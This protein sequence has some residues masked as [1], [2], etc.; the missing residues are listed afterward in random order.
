MRNPVIA[1]L[2]LRRIE[3]YLGGKSSTSLPAGTSGIAQSNIATGSSSSVLLP[4]HVT[5]TNNGHP[6]NPSNFASVRSLSIANSLSPI[7]SSVLPSQILVLTGSTVSARELRNLVATLFPIDTHELRIVS[8]TGFLRLIHEIYASSLHLPTSNVWDNALLHSGAPSSDSRSSSSSSSSSFLSSSSWS[9]TG[10]NRST[11]LSSRFESRAALRSIIHR[12][13]LEFYRPPN[14]PFKYLDIIHRYFEQLA[15]AGISPEEF[16]SGRPKFSSGDPIFSSS[17]SSSNHSSVSSVFPNLER[18]EISR[19]KELARAYNEWIM[20]KSRVG[21]LSS[22]DAILS[23]L[24]I[25]RKRDYVP[26]ILQATTSTEADPS[27]STFPDN[28]SYEVSHSAVLSYLQNEIRHVLC[29]DIEDYDLGVLRILHAAFGTASVQSAV[30]TTAEIVDSLS[31]KETKKKSTTKTRK[32]KETIKIEIDTL[33]PTTIVPPISATIRT[34]ELFM[35]TA[36]MNSQDCYTL[37]AKKQLLQSMGISSNKYYSSTTGLKLNGNERSGIDPI[38]PFQWYMYPVDS[39]SSQC[40]THISTACHR[41]NSANKI[42]EG[43]DNAT[44]PS[45]DTT[46]YLATSPTN[47]NSSIASSTTTGGSAKP[48]KRKKSTAS[49]TTPDATKQ[50]QS[51][52]ASSQYSEMSAQYAQALSIVPTVPGSSVPGFVECIGLQSTGNEVRAIAQSIK[53]LLTKEGLKDQNHSNKEYRSIAVLCKSNTVATEIGAALQNELSSLSLTLPLGFASPPSSD[54]DNETSINAVVSTKAGSKNST[55]NIYSDGHAELSRVPEVRWILAFLGVL[56]QPRDQSNWYTLASSPLYNIPLPTVADWVR[57]ALADPEQAGSVLRVIQEASAP[58]LRSLKGS[59]LSTKK[60]LPPRP[61]MELN[62]LASTTTTWGNG[63][64]DTEDEGQTVSSA[65]P[66]SSGSTEKLPRVPDEGKGSDSEGAFGIVLPPIR[67]PSDAILT[68]SS[69]QSL[70]LSSHVPNTLFPTVE[71]AARQLLDDLRG[72]T[73]EQN[74][75]GSVAKALAWY[76]RKTD[77]LT[78]LRE[79]T[80]PAQADAAAALAALLTLIHR[81]ERRQGSEGLKSA[82]RRLSRQNL[83]EDDFVVQQSSRQSESEVFNAILSTPTVKVELALDGLAPVFEAVK[84]AVYAGRLRYVSNSTVNNSSA[85]AVKQPTGAL[86]AAGGEGD[87]DEEIIDVVDTINLF[88]NQTVAGNMQNRATAASLSDSENERMIAVHSAATEIGLATSTVDDANGTVKEEMMEDLVMNVGDAASQKTFEQITQTVENDSTL[89]KLDK[90]LNNAE[91]YRIVSRTDPSSIVI[92]LQSLKGS[93]TRPFVVVTT[94]HRGIEHN[95]DVIIFPNCTNTS[96]P[97]RYLSDNL[98]LPVSLFTGTIG[99]PTVPYT[100]VS[101]DATPTSTS[102][103]SPIATKSTRP[104][105]N[106]SSASD[107]IEYDV[108]SPAILP[109]PN[110]RLEFEALSRAQLLRAMARAREGI[111]FFC[112]GVPT[113]ESGVSTRTSRSKWL[114]YIFGSPPLKRTRKSK[115]TTVN[116]EETEELP[117]QTNVILPSNTLVSSTNKTMMSVLPSL[118]FSSLSDYDWCPWKFKLRKIDKLVPLPAANVEYG[119]ALHASVAAVA[120]LVYRPLYSYLE[121]QGIFNDYGLDTRNNASELSSTD[122]AQISLQRAIIALDFGQRNSNATNDLKKQIISK[123][124]TMDYCTSVMLSAYKDSWVPTSTE[125]GSSVNTNDKGRSNTAWCA[126]YPSQSNLSKGIINGSLAKDQTYIRNAVDTLLLDA[127]EIRAYEPFALEAIHNFA[128]RELTEIRSLL[129]DNG[130]SYGNRLGSGNVSVL[131]LVEQHFQLSIPI[132]IPIPNPSSPTS[133]NN[134]DEKMLGNGVTDNH[135]T[136]NSNLVHLS[137]YIDRIDV[138]CLPPENSGQYRDGSNSYETNIREYKSGQQWKRNTSMALRDKLRTLQ[139]DIYGMAVKNM[140]TNTS[141]SSANRSRIPPLNPIVQVSVESIE[142]GNAESR[143]I[144]TT[145]IQK[146]HE[147]ILTLAERIRLQEFKP[148]PSEIA[149]KYCGFSNTC[150]S[151]YGRRPSIDTEQTRIET[152]TK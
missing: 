72:F 52:F 84:G 44:I 32:P 150:H 141:V 37:Q 73:E 139:P 19:H 85:A 24:N 80:T 9:F 138:Q 126:A 57:S 8:I 13:P 34:V 125:T 25:L 26:S 97:G 104:L 56:V 91:D 132:P 71:D 55:L 121:E 62:T 86:V 133:L 117:E 60:P 88:K 144:D 118:S 128:L 65:V 20:Y 89:Q 145:A 16:E 14:A 70:N 87:I 124:P 98:P 123:L 68:P 90:V 77:A 148:K 10:S 109:Y 50:I 3:H 58:K 45:T 61:A 112:P 119:K 127:E 76:I 96:Y 152:V 149:C 74:K 82:T 41:L 23:S 15:R 42:A 134:Y 51:L 63:W 78:P 30:S 103:S 12:L 105:E 48:S 108:S 22:S 5:H 2:L 129:T 17:S 53:T 95:Y 40:S 29:M 38:T 130:K 147:Q 146:A 101:N 136:N 66:N 35:D 111:L 102:T 140:I 1:S 28:K 69:N 99:V 120:E 93:T 64:S 106:V 6:N 143:I 94:F 110:D 114:D 31:K 43:T 122:I 39:L 83:Y 135:N 131:A 11:Q 18:Y 36:I 81:L 54:S 142:T 107:M 47:I 59:S 115:S 75:T 116:E 49:V 7:D 79:A 21:I 46:V 151:A 137:G 100:T 27:L 4:T 92:P 33:L 67:R 113:A